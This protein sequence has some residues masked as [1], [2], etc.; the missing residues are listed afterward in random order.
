[1]NYFYESPNGLSTFLFHKQ[2]NE[3]SQV[4]SVDLSDT[5]LFWARLSLLQPSD[6][7][8]CEKLSRHWGSSIRAPFGTT[9][10]SRQHGTDRLK[11][12]PQLG[13]HHVTD[14][15]ISTTDYESPSLAWLWVDDVCQALFMF[16]YRP[17][18]FYRAF[19]EK[20]SHAALSSYLKKR[21]IENIRWY[22]SKSIHFH[23]Y[24]IRVTRYH[25]RIT[26]RNVSL[27]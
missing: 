19:H 17:D 10:A 18:P 13:P 23:R 24:L 21:K 8:K 12:G 1:M 11:E 5:D 26:Y 22:P 2:D 15:T 7:Q 3:W 20:G 14:E 9:F 16:R 25:S 27:L 6:V 4:L